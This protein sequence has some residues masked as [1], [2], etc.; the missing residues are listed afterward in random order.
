MSDNRARA[1]KLFERAYQRQRD[2]DYA[3]AVM[4]YQASIAEHPTAEEREIW[5]AR[6]FDLSSLR[7]QYGVSVVCVD[8][9][10]GSSGTPALGAK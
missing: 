4:L 3:D 9:V 5:R 7:A 10:T 2:G 1:L 8:P 6:S